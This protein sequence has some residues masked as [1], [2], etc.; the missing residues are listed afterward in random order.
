[1]LPMLIS[2]TGERMICFSAI[3]VL[4][5]ASVLAVNPFQLWLLNKLKHLVCDFIIIA[6]VFIFIVLW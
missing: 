2:E 4:I 3:Y 5:F 1:M 6:G